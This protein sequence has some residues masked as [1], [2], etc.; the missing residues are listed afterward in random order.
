M[1][2]K[3]NSE[4]DHSQRKRSGS[5]VFEQI[6]TSANILDQAQKR[7]QGEGRIQSTRDI[8]WSRGLQSGPTFCK[9][10]VV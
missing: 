2:E 8:H 9:W 5:K 4:N 10:I 6:S 7:L 3:D 1:R